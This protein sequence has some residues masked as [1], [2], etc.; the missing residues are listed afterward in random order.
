MRRTSEILLLLISAVFLSACAGRGGS[1]SEASAARQFPAVTVPSVISDPD[2][3]LEYVLNHYWDDF[4]GVPMEG[5]EGAMA[6]FIALLDRAPLPVAQKAVEV[7]FHRICDAEKA[8]TSAHHYVLMTQMVSKYLYD[9]NSPLRNEDYY[10][11]FVRL[12][13]ESPLTSDDMRPAY[14]YEAEAC[15][16]C[17]SGTPAPDFV[18]KT[19]SGC[20]MNLYDTNSFYTLLFFSN[21]G[22]TACKTIVE[23]ISAVDGMESMI[24]SGYVSI[25]NV[26]IDEDLDAWKDYVRNYPDSWTSAYDRDRVIRGKRIYDVRAIPSLYLLDKDKVILMKDAPTEKVLA[27]ILNQ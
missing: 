23:E 26:Y 4:E 9:P 1:A 2:E 25:V 7:L 6:D 8:D 20:E 27:R 11:P 10:L 21:P 13:A 19:S 15:A 12:M 17:Q 24:E 18:M 14:R 3:R 22:C 5:M 16:V